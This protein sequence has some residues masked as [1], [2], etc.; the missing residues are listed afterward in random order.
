MAPVGAHTDQVTGDGAYLTL[1]VP[2]ILI[3]LLVL[4]LRWAFSR[5]HSLVARPPRSGSPSDYGLLVS[6]A[7]PTGAAAGEELCRLLA[8]NGIQATLASTR[9]G[10]RLMVWPAD[11]G[12]ARRLLDRD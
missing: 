2:L 7:A 10:L 4:I 12:R 8:D 11:V 1:L 5:G 3:G 9:A 6:V